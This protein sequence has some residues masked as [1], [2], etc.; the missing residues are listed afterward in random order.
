MQLLFAAVAQRYRMVFTP[1]RHG[2]GDGA[3]QQCHSTNRVQSTGSVHVD[4][5]KVSQEHRIGLW[6]RAVLQEGLNDIAGDTKQPLDPPAVERQ[7]SHDDSQI[8]N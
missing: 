2:D 5:C 6:G 3:I 7:R 1:R 4:L 8:F